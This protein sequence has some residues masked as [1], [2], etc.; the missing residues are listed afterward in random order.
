MT[1]LDDILERANEVMEQHEKVV[2]V[3]LTGPQFRHDW[4]GEVTPH[5]QQFD[6]TE[7]ETQ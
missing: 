5:C 2:R 4:R 7:T 3:R 6:G 1:V